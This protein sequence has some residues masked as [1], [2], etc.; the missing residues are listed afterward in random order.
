MVASMPLL[1][2]GFQAF[3]GALKCCFYYISMPMY[4]PGKDFLR[5]TSYY[6][7]NRMNL[8]VSE[9]ALCDHD[10]NLSFKSLKAC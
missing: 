8:S 4:I 3:K 6:E 7:F 2:D 5:T 10:K 9:E 1:T